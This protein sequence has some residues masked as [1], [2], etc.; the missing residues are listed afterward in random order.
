MKMNRDFFC[1]N[2]FQLMQ[3][4]YLNFIESAYH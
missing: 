3:L 1:H 2:Y 4:A